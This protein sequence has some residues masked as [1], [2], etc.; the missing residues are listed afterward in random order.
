MASEWAL[1]AAEE[2]E[3]VYHVCNLGAAK[4]RR[5]RLAD[6]IDAAWEEHAG[7]HAMMK[8]RDMGGG[9]AMGLA[10]MEYEAKVAR[11]VAAAK[12]YRDAGTSTTEWNELDQALADL[13][14]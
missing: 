4:E 11:L 2:W 12:A 7:R 8:G 14:K 1:K 13:E 3:P 10:I 6:I 9:A 5:M